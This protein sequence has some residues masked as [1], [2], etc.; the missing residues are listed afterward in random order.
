MQNMKSTV[1]DVQEISPHIPDMLS[2][3]YKNVQDEINRLEVVDSTK[4]WL[5]QMF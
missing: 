2:L 4:S 5:E 3:M 1:I